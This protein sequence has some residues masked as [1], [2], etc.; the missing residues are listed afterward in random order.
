VARRPAHISPSEDGSMTK[1]LS[2]LAMVGLI[3]FATAQDKK[4]EKKSEAFDAKK[5]VGEWSIESGLKAGSKSGDE[6]KKMVATIDKE[7]VL[8]MKTPDGEFVFKLKF[9]EKKTP[10][11]VDIEILDGPIGKGSTTKGIAELKGDEF[12]LCYD[13]TG[14]GD[15][16]AKFDGEKANLFVL[17]KKKADK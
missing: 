9:D 6:I 11:E 2:V 16:P 5:L 1:F 12:K 14:M 8:K 10:V 17:K 7:G 3:G 4:D 15:R 13:G